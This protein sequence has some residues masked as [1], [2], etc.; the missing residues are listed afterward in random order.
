MGVSV[1]VGF[2]YAHVMGWY[3]WNLALERI[4]VASDAASGARVRSTVL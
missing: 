3:G 2:G 1:A 4:R